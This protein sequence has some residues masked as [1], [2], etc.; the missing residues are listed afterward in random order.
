MTT[1]ED[2]AKEARW[3][4]NRYKEITGDWPDPMIS[5][6]VEMM[7]VEYVRSVIFRHVIEKLDKAAERGK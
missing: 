6:G 4:N 5:L 7:H 2:L 1:Q 3:L